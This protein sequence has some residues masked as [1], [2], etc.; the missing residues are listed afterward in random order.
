MLWWRRVWCGASRRLQGGLA[1]HHPQRHRHP[2][3]GQHRPARHQGHVGAE[4]RRLGQRHLG[5]HG[6]PLLRRPNQVRFISSLH[7]V[8]IGMEWDAWNGTDDGWDRLPSQGCWCCAARK[9]RRRRSPAW[10]RT[11][12]PSTAATSATRTSSCRS[13]P[14]ASAS[15]P[16][17]TSS[18][19]GSAV[20]LAFLEFHRV[21]LVFSTF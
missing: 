1:A 12:R 19:S 3:T 9:W 7:L 2:R 4:T 20:A 13:P 5:W 16:S 8:G 14:A 17:R 6:R 21:F 11:S 10:S 15:S 18:R